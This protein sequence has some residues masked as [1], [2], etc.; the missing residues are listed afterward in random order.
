MKWPSIPRFQGLHADRPS[1]PFLL[2]HTYLKVVEVLEELGVFDMTR[3][4]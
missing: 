2:A 4:N 1:I 3:V